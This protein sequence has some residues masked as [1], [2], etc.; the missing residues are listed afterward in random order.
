MWNS[1]RTLTLLAGV[2]ATTQLSAAIDTGG[3]L[4]Y[5]T[6]AGGSNVHKVDYSWIGGSLTIANNTAIAAVAGAD[7]ILFLPNGNLA[8]GGQGFGVHEL[9]LAGSLVTT[10]GVPTPSFHLSLS[11]GGKVLYSSGIPG[12]PTAIT[13]NGSGGLTGAAAALLPTAGSSTTLDTISWATGG[14]NV[15]KSLYT[16]SAP[17][18]NGVVGT[19]TFTGGPEAPTAATTSAPVALPASHG[20]AYDP[21]SD[22]FITM[23]DTEISRFSSA[24]VLLET[25]DLASLG[26]STFDQG[27][28]DGLGH[29]FGADNGGRLVMID[30]SATGT[31][32][33]A[34]TVADSIFLHSALDDIA[35]KV[36]PGSID[37]IPEPATILVWSVL[38]CVGGF[39]AYRRRRA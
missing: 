11:P 15:G 8:I 32:L 13:L 21:F 19:I 9:T 4:Y 5:T 35:P 27:T 34:S 26:I 16:S 37:E 25:I 28:V 39:G 18:G 36:G 2:L 29:I 10:L 12:S 24:G 17:G 20:M 14:P 6:F 30:Y 31:L 33:A 23:G 38:A 3:T 7:G 22:S 1:L